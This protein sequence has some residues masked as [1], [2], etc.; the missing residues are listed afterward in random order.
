[1]Y[2]QKS[3][4]FIRPVVMAALLLSSGFVAADDEDFELSADRFTMARMAIEEAQEVDADASASSELVLAERKYQAAVENDD[5]GR[6][7]VAARLLKQSMLHAEHAEVMGLQAQADVSLAELNAAHN[8]LE[9][10]L[11]R[12]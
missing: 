2:I 10:E 1:M 6:E 12:R 8:S 5:D 7:E 3:D 4:K 9:S 11:R